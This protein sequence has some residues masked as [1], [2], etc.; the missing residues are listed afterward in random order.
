VAFIRDDEVT[1][2]KFSD[3][4]EADIMGILHEHAATYKCICFMEK[5]G[6]ARGRDGRKQGVSST[7]KF[8]VAYGFVRGVVVALKIPFHEVSPQKWQKA[9][10]CMTRGDKNVSKAAAQRLFPA[11]KIT[12]AVADA[13]LIAEYG[14]RNTP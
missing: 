1:C 4:T 10:G 12:H 8:G 11:L 13:L 7:F 14:R 2:Y 3:K 5:V 9:M 6:P